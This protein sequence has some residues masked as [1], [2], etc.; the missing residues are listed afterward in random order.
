MTLFVFLIVYTLSIKNRK[1]KQMESI[2]LEKVHSANDI[3]LCYARENNVTIKEAIEVTL[4]QLSYNDF[5]E[6]LKEYK[7]NF[8]K[9]K[10]LTQEY[11]KIINDKNYSNLK[12]N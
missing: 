1:G 11:E 7:I 4:L 12:L 9:F 2:S 8:D 10:I 5:L 3:V 6:H